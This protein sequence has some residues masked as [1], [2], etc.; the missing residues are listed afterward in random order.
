MKIKPRFAVIFFLPALPLIIAIGIFLLRAPVLVVSDQYFNDLYGKHRTLFA[1]M[2][3]SISLFRRFQLVTVADDIGPDG[4]AFAVSEVSEHPFCVCF[5]YRYADGARN[6]QQLYPSVNVLLFMGRT[7][8]PE[9]SESFTLVQTDTETDLYRA[10]LGAAL[11]SQNKA[12]KILCY[13]ERGRRAEGIP[14]FEWGLKD[15]GREGD[16]LFIDLNGTYSDETAISCIVLTGSSEDSFITGQNIP[17]LLYSWAD[18]DIFPPRVT[19]I[20][21][22]SLW[23]TVLPAVKMLA[24][25]EKLISLPSIIQMHPQNTFSSNEKNQLKNAFLQN[26][27]L[28]H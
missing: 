12:G 4:I 6:Y 28:I 14:F 23:E 1:E 17:I 21:S 7:R 26:K 19:V 9:L 27:P 22:D 11:I 25:G 2:K 24:S 5:P 3:S 13:I 20:F 8:N 10:G 16:A 18:P 15:G